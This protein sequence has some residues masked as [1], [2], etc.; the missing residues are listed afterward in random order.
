LRSFLG[1]GF[2]LAG[3]VLISIIFLVSGYNKITHYAS[4][5]GYMQ[6]AGIPGY[7]LP[8]VIA[9]E[10]GGGLL[11]LSGFLTRIAAFLL[12]G[13]T[14]VAAYFFHFNFADQGQLLQLQKDM[15]IAGGLLFAM[16]YGAGGWSLDAKLR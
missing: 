14:L 7:L 11:L 4:T 12:A 6:K 3:R 5:V 10:L 1:N 13:F 9:V 15:A 16:M 8:M 2:P